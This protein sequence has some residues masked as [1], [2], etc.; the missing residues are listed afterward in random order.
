MRTSDLVRLWRRGEIAYEQLTIAERERLWQIVL[1]VALESTRRQQVRHDTPSVGVVVRP[2]C[3][4][5]S[6][7]QATSRESTRFPKGSRRA[8]LRPR[9][10]T[11]STSFM[12]RCPNRAE[13]VR[14]WYGGRQTRADVVGSL[15]NLED[16]RVLA[17]HQRTRARRGLECRQQ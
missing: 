10:I 11:G 1:E 12:L 13:D 2:D 6:T 17:F 15:F 9:C 8:S 5:P 14:R 7:P 16:G 4:G 3:I